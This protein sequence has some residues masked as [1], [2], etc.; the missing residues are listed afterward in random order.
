MGNREK[1]LPIEWEGL[2]ETDY[3]SCNF[4]N[5]TFT[6]DFGIVKE[7]DKFT[8]VYVDYSDGFLQL[9]SDNVYNTV[10]YFKCVPI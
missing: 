6:A 5:V 7:G 8:S 1:S 4:Y 9:Y 3:D 10:I 2:D